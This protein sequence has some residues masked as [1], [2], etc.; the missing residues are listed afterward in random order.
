MPWAQRVGFHGATPLAP[1]ESIGL[2]GVTATATPGAHA[3]PEVTFVL[4]HKG[5]TVY[6]G[7]DSL[8]IPELDKI[9]R[10]FPKIDLALLPI[11]G[12]C[13][14]PLGDRQVV[15]NPLEAADLVRVLKPRVA[16]PI[17]YAFDAGPLFN[18]TILKY[19]DRQEALPHL[20]KDAASRYA[21]V[22]ILKPGE[23]LT[24]RSA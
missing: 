16:V 2:N 10:R 21:K 13:I 8:R 9:A 3:V 24:L 4:Q 18:R 12:L 11:N 20:F 7:G 1:W 22:K 17:H 15:M 23:Q 14:R 5:F 6:F 19:Y